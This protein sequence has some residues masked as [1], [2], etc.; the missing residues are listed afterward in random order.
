MIILLCFIISKLFSIPLQEY[1]LFQSGMYNMLNNYIFLL[2]LLGLSLLFLNSKKNIA[3]ISYLVIFLLVYI[4]TLIFIDSILRLIFLYNLDYLWGFDKFPLLVL[5]FLSILLGII[6]W[7]N[8]INNLVKIFLIIIF[9][10]IISFHVALKEIEI[11]TLKSFISFPGGNLLIIVWLSI[12]L[13]YLLKK[14]NKKYVHIFSKIYGSW[15]ITIGIIS[16]IFS[17]LY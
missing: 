15:L 10:F 17:L 14:F 2:C 4:S 5:Y 3:Y 7:F 12:I 11:F 1:G 8:P 9:S 16:A 6:L 13:I